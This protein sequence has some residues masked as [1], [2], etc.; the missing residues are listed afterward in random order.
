MSR[1]LP[2]KEFFTTG[3]IARLLNITR[4]SVYRWVKSG[5]LKAYRV[6]KGRYRILRKDFIEFLKNSG[7]GKLLNTLPQIIK[8]LIVDD[9]PHIVESLKTFLEKANHNFHIR[10]TTSGFEAGRLIYSFMPDVVIVDL[11][12]PGMDGFEICRQIKKDPLTR[13]IKIIAITGYPTREKIEK[14]KEEGASAVF[15][16]PF[17][18]NELLKE[19]KRLI[20]K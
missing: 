16:K 5:K 14:I 1:K 10:G 20:K 11:V 8:I 13:H 7:M 9:N 4:I 6:P 2:P 3:E 15:S 19:I 12:M 18:Y 17:D